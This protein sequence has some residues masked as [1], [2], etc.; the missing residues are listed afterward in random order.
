MSLGMAGKATKPN[1]FLETGVPTPSFAKVM[2]RGV[3]SFQPES[4]VSALAKTWSSEHAGKY[5][6]HG[7][8]YSRDVALGSDFIA[9]L[10][11]NMRGSA[12]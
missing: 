5:V 11:G 1:S 6:N 3:E 12:R 4:A 10:G 9:S 7:P 8:A 2:G